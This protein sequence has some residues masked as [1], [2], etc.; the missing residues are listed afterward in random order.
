[1]RVFRFA[2]KPELVLA[3]FWDVNTGQVSETN[4][5][6]TVEDLNEELSRSLVF[7]FGAVNTAILPQSAYKEIDAG[8]RE[9]F[10]MKHK[11]SV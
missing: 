11:G 4:R 7:L 2:Y 3:A 9:T 8:F 10:G 6:G 1:V 5:I